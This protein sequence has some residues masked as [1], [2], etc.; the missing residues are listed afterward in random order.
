MR[1]HPSRSRHES[2]HI[3]HRSVASRHQAVTD[4]SRIRHESSRVVASRRESS[5]GRR[6]RRGRHG[7]VADPSRV[8]AGR[9]GSSRV[10]TD[11]SRIRRGSVTSRREA[12]PGRRRVVTESSQSVTDSS[13]SVTVRHLPSTA[14]TPTMDP[15]QTG[16]YGQCSV[17]CRLL[18]QWQ[19][20]Q[21]TVALV[22]LL[23][24]PTT[25]LY[26]TVRPVL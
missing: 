12:S 16:G 23:V 19:C 6:G 2:S 14:T 8:V 21:S 1:H 18:T 25:T 10:V 17:L 24:A 5:P 20:A 11:P 9:R 13:R 4:P 7:S 15:H 26:R 3:R 22:L